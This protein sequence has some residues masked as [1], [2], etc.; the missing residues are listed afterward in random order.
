ME[1]T[2]QQKV[3]EEET[4]NLEEQ[5]E[6]ESPKTYTQ[7][8]VEEMRK[9]LQSDSEK[10]VQK[11]IAE[12]KLY[13]RAFKESGNIAQD[14]SRLVEIFNEDPKLAQVILDEY[15]N[16]QSIDEYKESIGY[17]EDLTDPKVYE[18]RLKADT[19]KAVAKKQLE[20]EKKSFIAKLKMSD[21]EKEAFESQLEELTSLKSFKLEN[22]EKTMEKAYRLIANEE[23]TKK[24]NTQKVIA[25]TMATTKWGKQG[26][27]GDWK[28]EFQKDLE[29][30]KKRH[31]LI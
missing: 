14:D 16:G 10:W 30:F 1:D 27:S 23:D 25:E 8:E 12:K 22:I 15:F 28:T 7:E 9:K 26:K 6:E 18:A 19:E 13:E 3:Q 20:S 11:V 2:T 29:A 4:L 31:K 24:L 5:G 17:Q 21:E